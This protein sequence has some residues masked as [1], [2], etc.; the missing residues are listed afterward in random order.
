MII[1]LKNKFV[2]GTSLFYIYATDEDSAENSRVRCILNDTRLN[3]VYLTLN[4]YSLQISGSP[5]FD[6]EIEQFTSI[7]L[8]CSDD[9][10]P[11]LSKT[12]LFQIKLEDCNDNPPDIISPLP[13]NH[14]LLIPFETATTPF[15][16]SQFIVED[17]DRFQINSFTYSFTVTPLLDLSL[18]NNGTLILSSMPS[19]LGVYTI[20]V[21]VYDRG[22]L[23][24]SISIPIS[25]YSINETSLMK[26]LHVQNPIV[27]LIILFVVIFVVS[28]LIGLCHLILHI[29]RTRKRSKT[30]LCSCCY[31]CFNSQR[32]SIR[33][34]SC[35]SM[36]SSNERADS[37][38]KTTIEV[39]DD[40]KVSISL[41]FLCLLCIVN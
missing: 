35:E 22:N 18:S 11:S 17:R 8:S 24:N 41:E 7:E 29:L 34:S 6:Y 5:L 9:G 20:N 33:D 1:K 4:A 10:F 31:A 23:T 30:C 27:F 40:G 39:L 14:T 12:V 3:L 16:L 2:L 26:N 36:N 28:L 21:T 13:F 25:I 37:L 32:K 15:I 19:K 38:Q